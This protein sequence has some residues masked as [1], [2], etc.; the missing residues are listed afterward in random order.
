MNAELLDDYG[1]SLICK[2]RSE[3]LTKHGYSVQHDA[4]YDNNELV[5]AA[6]AILTHDPRRWPWPDDIETWRRI[7]RKPSPEQLAIAGALLAAEISANKL[8]SDALE[9]HETGE[10]G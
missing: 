10:D 3:Q 2:E 5:L 7:E 4:G 9:R 6:A 8:F 1:L